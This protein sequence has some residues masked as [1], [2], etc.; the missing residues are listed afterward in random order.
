[1]IERAQRLSTE[2]PFYP[3]KDRITNIDS[4]VYGQVT[5][6]KYHKA[7]DSIKQALY[8]ETL[9]EIRRLSSYEGTWLPWINK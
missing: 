5:L 3:L 4:V 1:M 2:H 9:A 8:H 7:K 6:G